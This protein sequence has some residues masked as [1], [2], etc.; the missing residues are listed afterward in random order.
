MIACISDVTKLTV[1]K[2]TK[3]YIILLLLYEFLIFTKKR[4][5]EMTF[6]ANY[7]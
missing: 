6:I 3:G 4:N 2:L 5:T 1:W 7:V